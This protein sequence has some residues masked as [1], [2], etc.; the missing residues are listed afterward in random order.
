MTSKLQG[1]DLSHGARVLFTIKF[2]SFLD[3]YWGYAFICGQVLILNL[4]DSH[5]SNTHSSGLEQNSH[6]GR[7]WPW[8]KLR[9]Q[10][11]QMH[12]VCGQLALK[13]K[14]EEGAPQMSIL[15]LQ[16][17]Q[18]NE[19]PLLPWRREE[20]DV[21]QNMYYFT[22]ITSLWKKTLVMKTCP[23]LTYLS[24]TF[25][26]FS[27]LLNWPKPTVHQGCGEEISNAS[28]KSISN[29]MRGPITVY[30]GTTEGN[31]RFCLQRALK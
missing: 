19:L 7:G 10:K 16:N 23:M 27:V 30:K 17:S 11:G 21:D 3:W 1:S 18:P 20:K 9:G 6:P 13:R 25:S 12:D 29:F 4:M 15:F 8:P 22:G 5:P 26:N 14:E 28:G 2:C 31:L 24:T